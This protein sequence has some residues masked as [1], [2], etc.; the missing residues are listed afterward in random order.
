M[1]ALLHEQLCHGPVHFALLDFVGEMKAIDH[2]VGARFHYGE[3]DGFDEAAAAHGA[4]NA[5]G[6]GAQVIPVIDFSA[7]APCGAAEGSEAVTVEAVDVDF[8][9]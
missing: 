3:G 2:L 1:R 8:A 5:A 9:S 4:V 6:F 7:Y